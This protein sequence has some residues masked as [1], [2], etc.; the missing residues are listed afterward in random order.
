MPE[1]DP[2]A[3]SR[4]GAAIRL[5]DGRSAECEFCG[6]QFAAPA[7]VS[8]LA[9]APAGDARQVAVELTLR[10]LKEEQD[11]RLRER[12]SLGPGPGGGCRYLA[13]LFLLLPVVLFLLSGALSLLTP[14]P[15]VIAGSALLVGFLGWMAV[16]DLIRLAARRREHEAKFLALTE[17]IDGLQAKIDQQ[18]ASEK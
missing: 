17:E 4:C 9:A 6:S 8:P 11:A 18:R 2:L 5:G 3:C 7:G 14:T 15:P 10:R 16:R 12:A 13:G 1:I